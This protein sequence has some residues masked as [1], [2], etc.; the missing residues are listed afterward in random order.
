DLAAAFETLDIGHKELPDSQ[1]IIDEAAG[2]AWLQQD[3][4][5]LSDYVESLKAI[6]GDRGTEWRAFRAQILLADL[7]TNDDPDYR[8]V[9]SL[10]QT[11]NRIRPNWPK[12]N[13]S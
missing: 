11:I 1:E 3:W 13:T 8:E 9:V 5:R 4:D 6:E 2:L 10:I 12:G 7:A